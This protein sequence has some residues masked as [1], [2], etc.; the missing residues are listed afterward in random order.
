MQ[1]APGISRRNRRARGRKKQPLRKKK[2]RN[3]NQTSAREKKTTPSLTKVFPC[4]RNRPHRTLRLRLLEKEKSSPF[5]NS[6]APLEFGWTRKWHWVCFSKKTCEPKSGLWRRNYA[7]RRMKRN[8]SHVVPRWR[9]L[10]L[11]GS[12]MPP[13]KPSGNSSSR[14]LTR[15]DANKRRSA[16]PKATRARGIVPN[17]TGSAGTT[18]A[19]FRFRKNCSRSGE[20]KRRMRW[21]R[22]MATRRCWRRWRRYGG[23]GT[24]G[25]VRIRQTKTSP[26]ASARR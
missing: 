9:L 1:R 13:R 10:H 8:S 3:Q 19:A 11:K 17:A 4:H 2:R 26:D 22:R 24:A 21:W 20:R 14:S 23:T 16:R 12:W 18:N 5:A 6:C 15:H 7:R 25:F